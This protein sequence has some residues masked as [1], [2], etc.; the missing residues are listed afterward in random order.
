[1]GVNQACKLFPE[2]GNSG[3]GEVCHYC[4]Y[5]IRGGTPHHRIS[6]LQ[7]H[8]VKRPN[9]NPGWAI[10]IALAWNWS[11]GGT[12]LLRNDQTAFGLS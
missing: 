1:M 10:F 4:Q 12:L 3:F 8:P 5:P 2:R 9:F 7:A 11:D 6:I